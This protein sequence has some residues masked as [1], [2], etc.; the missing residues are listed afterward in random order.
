MAYGEVEGEIAR[1]V[2]YHIIYLE[3]LATLTSGS[4]LS[5]SSNEELYT[6]KIPQ[7]SHDTSL[8]LGRANLDSSSKNAHSSSAMLLSIGLY[9]MTRMM[10]KVVEQCYSNRIPRK[11]DSSSYSRG[12]FD[13]VVLFIS[14]RDRRDNTGKHMLLVSVCMLFTSGS[15]TAFTLLQSPQRYSNSVTPWRLT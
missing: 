14:L 8:G 5:H 13:S 2:W 11:A 9:E 15:S 1:R 3:V 6:T 10:R 7:E 12:P 4:S